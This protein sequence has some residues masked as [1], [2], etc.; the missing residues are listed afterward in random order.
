MSAQAQARDAWLSGSASAAETASLDPDDAETVAD[1]RLAIALH[2]AAPE[3]G[4]ASWAACERALARI[5]PTAASMA[6]DRA[7][8]RRRLLR[9]PVVLAAAALLLAA[10]GLVL[11]SV[12]GG[13]QATPAAPL[14]ADLVAVRGTVQCGDRPATAG[15]HWSPGSILRCADGAEAELRFADGST[16]ALLGATL[17]R[18]DAGTLFL[19][20]GLLR[21]EV[22]PREAQRAPFAI[23]TPLGQ[24]TVLGTLYDLRAASD[25]VHLR[26][27]RGRV[28][29]ANDEGRVLVTAD[30][31]LAIAADGSL[32]ETDLPSLDP[33]F[34]GR[35][36]VA[37]ADRYATGAFLLDDQ[38]RD[39]ELPV[40]Q[41]ASGAALVDRG[42][43]E[44][45]VT[46]PAESAR[47]LPDASGS[48]RVRLCV[49]PQGAER[50]RLRCRFRLVQLRSHARYEVR[51]GKR[52]SPPE[53]PEGLVLLRRDLDIDDE[54]WHGLTIDSLVVGRTRSGLPI[55][56][57]LIRLDGRPV[58]HDWHADLG[59]VLAIH[60]VG[61]PIEL[62]D[63]V[64]A[65]G[66]P[67]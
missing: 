20:E 48:A 65:G 7:L 39:E 53:P 58:V 37:A 67:R 15:M 9:R 41:A 49:E 1:L 35:F 57:T 56:E 31:Q 5:G 54:E 38:R 62:G 61:N 4:P 12:S 3:R 10:F 22:H 6:A 47:I 23:G 55:R 16:L 11:W 59:G 64:I 2:A 66:E 52:W 50:L 28:A 18:D 8:P 43:R 19:A 33:R 45:V 29:F 25:A 13:G 26:V 51:A 30:R 34:G 60:S 36:R 14:A 17:R 24:A 63:L 21:A 44:D 40:R 46:T 32:H 42:V 27:H